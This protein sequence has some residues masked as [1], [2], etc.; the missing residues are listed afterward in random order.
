MWRFWK[1]FVEEVEERKESGWGRVDVG[2]AEVKVS[3]S[4]SSAG[5][6]DVSP[7]V[8]VEGS[9]AAVKEASLEGNVAS[10]FVVSLTG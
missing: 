9:E 4:S 1:R 10:C 7:S 3:S 8:S 2:S 5:V 6:V